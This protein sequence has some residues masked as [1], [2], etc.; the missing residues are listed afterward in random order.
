MKVSVVIPAYNAMTYL[1]ET[2]E[3]VLRQTFTDFEV[4]IV[5][6][7]SSDQIV[8]WASG[9]VDPRVKLISQENQGSPGARN[10]GIAHA[11]GEYVAFLDADDLWS[12][13]KLEKQICC[14][15][16]NPAVGLVNTWTVLIDQLG[17]P[18]GRA[19]TFQAEGDVW[20]QIVLGN[21]LVCSSVVVRRC[22]FETVGVFEPNLILC[23]DWD[24][25]IRIASRYSVA[26]VKEPLAYYR[27][28]LNNI[29]KNYR[30][31]LQ[32][33]RTVIEKAF[34]SVPSELLY[35][36]NRSYGYANLYLAWRSLQSRDYQAVSHF[37]QQALAHYSQLRYSWD[38]IRLSIAIA[39]M[40]LFGPQAYD[41]LRT[42]LYSLRQRM[43]SVAQ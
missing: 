40:H 13:T 5:N 7:G 31:F 8:E 34:A 36:R 12:P 4:L 1:P 6:D 14:L 32:D 33:S 19:G 23:E 3:S 41:R 11:Q 26:V 27:Q 28:H 22:C 24:M 38:S 17:K 9:L 30:T 42:F 10:T 2:L 43:S 39:V 20:K 35:L 15:E 16:D 25:W 18:V 29:S 37:R 21:F